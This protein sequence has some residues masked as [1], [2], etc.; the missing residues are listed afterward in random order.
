MHPSPSREQF[1]TG[2]NPSPASKQPKC[3]ELVHRFDNPP[4][5]GGSVP[6]FL[7]SF[8]TTLYHSYS[9]LS[10]L[11]CTISSRLLLPVI[12]TST[13]NCRSANCSPLPDCR[14]LLPRLSELV[15]YQPRDQRNCTACCDDNSAHK[16]F[17]KA[18][19]LQ[20]S[21]PYKQPS[22]SKSP[23][24][25]TISLPSTPPPSSRHPTCCRTTPDTAGKTQ[26]AGITFHD[27]ISDIR[28]HLYGP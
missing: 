22:T 17:T 15:A 14:P 11:P 5:Q 20:T 24:R 27:D 28:N 18:G 8:G 13:Q 7:E 2:T 3:L 4:T 16:P 26:K 9:A 21:Q 1:P 25:L 23:L 10:K 12:N 6:L 19:I